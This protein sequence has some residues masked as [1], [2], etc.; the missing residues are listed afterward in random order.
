MLIKIRYMKSLHAASSVLA[1]KSSILLV[2]FITFISLTYGLLLAPLA[3]AKESS[4]VMTGADIRRAILSKVSI[5]MILEDAKESGLGTRDSVSFLIRAGASAETVLY[6]ALVN[7]YQKSEAIEAAIVEGMDT[8]LVFL[9]T[10]HAGI[11][12]STVAEIAVDMGASA[13]EVSD[14]MARVLLPRPT[15]P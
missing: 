8:E 2:I 13:E 7:G 15:L 14:L 1:Y 11:A 10:L 6:F 12:P 9:T 4:G 5:P 3:E